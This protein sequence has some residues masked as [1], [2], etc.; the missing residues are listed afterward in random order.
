MGYFLSAVL[1]LV[2]TG[3]YC[4][5]I[6]LPHKEL[7]LFTK[8]RILCI[9][10]S[11]TFGAGVVPMRWRDSYPAILQQKLGHEYQVLNYGIS[12]ATMQLSSD[13]PYSQAFV[14]AAEK[15]K[16]E[17]CIL[18]LGTNDS[19]AHNWNPESF[20]K[21]LNKRISRIQSFS[22]APKI[23]LVIPPA[24]FG[25]PIAYEIDDDI[26]REQIRP[27]L[28]QYAKA[29]RFQVIDFYQETKAHPEWFPDGV[30][31]NRKG[32]QRIAEIAYRKLKEI[33]TEGEIKHGD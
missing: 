6:F 19:K 5:W 17:I 18:M 22:S 1:L 27:I 10:D 25:N 2:V 3:M 7:P 14:D 29:K 31:P 13:K 23:I 20:A 9:G 33:L 12:G 4:W 16:P 28:I 8:K 24:A 11:I 26:I 15:T 21:D 32:N 30:H